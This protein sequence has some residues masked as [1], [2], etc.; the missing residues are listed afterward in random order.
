MPVARSGES[1]KAT[2]CSETFIKAFCFA[3]FP[4]IMKSKITSKRR[5]FGGIQDRAR[6][7]ERREPGKEGTGRGRRSSAAMVRG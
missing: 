4:C 2:G 3:E 6:D 7:E 5:E 1:I